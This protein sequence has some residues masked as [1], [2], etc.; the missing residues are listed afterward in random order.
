MNRSVGALVTLFLTATAGMTQNPSHSYTSPTI[1]SDVTLQ[2]LNLKLGWRTYVPMDGRRDSIFSVQNAGDLLLVQT[3]SGLV[4]AVETETGR[5]RWQARLGRPY[6]VSVRLGYNSQA[7]YVVNDQTLYV[8]DRNT[9]ALLWDFDMPSAATTAP[10]ADEAQVFLSLRGGTVSAYAI[11]KPKADGFA[12]SKAP[13]RR[14]EDKP[15]QQTSSGSSA[16]S[17]AAVGGSVRV[18]G[19]MGGSGVGLTSSIGAL[20]SATGKGTRTIANIGPLSSARQTGGTA[21]SGVELLREWSDASGLRLEVAPVQTADSLFLVDADGRVA[22]LQKGVQQGQRYKFTL[23]DGPVVV[24]PGIYADKEEAYVASQDS[25]LYAVRIP[26]GGLKWRFTTG[27]PI[28]DRP[29]VTDADIYI[30]TDRGGLRRLDRE[31]GRVVWQTRSAHRFLAT[32]PKVVYATDRTGNLLLVDRAN[33]V[34]VGFCDARD[35][36]V[37]VFN[38]LTDRV[39]FASNDGLLV[40]LH[41]RDLAKPHVNKSWE[42]KRPGDKKRGDKGKDMPKPKPPRENKEAGDQ[43]K[44]EEMEKKS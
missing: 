28:V 39:F 4:C 2:P 1:P 36:T 11:P 26:T 42:L 40:C 8:L 17:A 23:A 6:R 33:G 20:A 19:S 31:T 24:P 34:Q 25:N 15:K 3:R 44:A 30:T 41:D 35:F 12:K 7:V 32:S 43:N 5:V 22:C 29:A 13:P 16:A 9:G 21:T 10:V 14:E 38:D 27:T 18:S 37:P